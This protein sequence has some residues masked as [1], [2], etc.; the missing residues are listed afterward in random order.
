MRQAIDSA[1]FYPFCD[2]TKNRP[3]KTERFKRL[4]IFSLLEL[5]VQPNPHSVKIH[6]AFQIV[7]E[8]IRIRIVD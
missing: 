3:A 6:L 7:V 8:Q 4:E 1:R 2:Q 5:V